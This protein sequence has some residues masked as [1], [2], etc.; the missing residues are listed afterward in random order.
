MNPK[1]T[2]P[3]R[4]VHKRK[5]WSLTEVLNRGWLIALAPVLLL[6]T[7][8]SAVDSRGVEHP[9]S[10]HADDNC[11]SCHAEKSRGKSVHSAMELPCT[12]CHLAQTNG[13]MTTLTLL[14]PKPKLCFACHEETWSVGQHRPV[15]KRPCL[16]CHD[17]HSSNQRMLLREL[18]HVGLNQSQEHLW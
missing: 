3:R 13:D 15:T 4:T 11:S 8:V 6:G 9:G 2:A 18:S 12:S 16:D 14:M 1:T 5:L 10:V 17:A 7:R